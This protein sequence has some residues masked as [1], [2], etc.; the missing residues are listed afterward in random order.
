MYFILGLI[1]LIFIFYLFIY[2]EWSY[3]GKLAFKIVLTYI[4]LSITVLMMILLVWSV[5]SAFSVEKE[6]TLASR[7]DSTSYPFTNGYYA[8]LAYRLNNDMD[9]EPEFEH[10]WERLRIYASYNQYLVYAAANKQEL[11]SGTY[12]AEEEYYKNLFIELC[13]DPDYAENK[14][15]GEY[16]LNLKEIGED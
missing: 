3:K 5:G 7:L 4:T 15:F 12:E 1:G 8:D 16:Y 14:D 11:L 13:K 2:R 9:Y 10:M 6:K